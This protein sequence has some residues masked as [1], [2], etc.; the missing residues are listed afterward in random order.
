MSKINLKKFKDIKGYKGIY[1]I[2]KDGLIYTHN[3]NRF[4]KPFPDKNT[5]LRVLLSKNSSI[6]NKIVHRLVAETFIPNPKNLPQVNHKDGNKQ[7]NNVN[8]LEWCTNLQNIR[9]ASENGLLRGRK[10][11]THHN[12]KLTE[13]N[14]LS[15]R[16]E[17]L[18][19]KSVYEIADK[20]GIHCQHVWRICSKGRWG[21][22]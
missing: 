17:K 8:N 11:I 9:H 6:K 21:H 4:L 19:G 1:C 22:I 13:D 2:N 16:K 15:I 10:G 12:A 14:V 7:N 20:Y 5:Y 3:Y 18:E